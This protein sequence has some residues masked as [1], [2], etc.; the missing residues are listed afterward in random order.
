MNLISDNNDGSHNRFRFLQRKFART[1][2]TL[3]VAGIPA[4]A[5]LVFVGSASATAFTTPD[6]LVVHTA[7]WQT[8]GIN[9]W[10]AIVDAD[11]R[12]GS[13]SAFNAEA[14]HLTTADLAGIEVV[15][16]NTNYD[17]LDTD[18]TGDLLADF[19]DQGGRVIETTYAFACTTDT[20]GPIGWG[21]GGRWED[22]GY[23]AITPIAASGGACAGYD[24][25][26]TQ[27]L[28]VLV[29]SSPFLANVGSVSGVQT[30]IN[31]DLQ[32]SPG[33]VVLAEWDSPANMPAIVVGS[34]CVMG[35]SMYIPH[36][37][38]PSK[39]SNSQVASVTNLFANL[40]TLSCTAST[41]SSSTTP[42]SSTTPS[43]STTP[44]NGVAPSTT[45]GPQLPET[46]SNGSQTNAA[47]AFVL[48]AIGAIMIGR[49]RRSA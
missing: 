8:P 36:I 3:A 33:A 2:A 24:L 26:E 7:N 11:P 10:V 19:V 47:V 6:V 32:A 46:G 13:V 30:G 41:P 42:T 44:A 23:A 38:D 22:D 29:Q 25:N 27:T 45:S 34:N 37:V 39:Y 20:A 14:N 9:G 40:A 5:G 15:V 4:T 28:Q 21:L 16:V 17:F 18:E 12:F 48:L 1:A 35:V 43:S 49:S 31:T